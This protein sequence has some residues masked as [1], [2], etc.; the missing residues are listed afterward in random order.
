MVVT[1]AWERHGVC[2]YDLT[3]QRLWQDRSRTNVEAVTALT[4]GSSIHQAVAFTPLSAGCAG[5]RGGKVR[6]GAGG[7]I[8][9]GFSNVAIY[10]YLHVPWYPRRSCAGLENCA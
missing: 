2:G 3:G 7:M 1:G 8:V 4:G 10:R 9:E 5:A 6:D